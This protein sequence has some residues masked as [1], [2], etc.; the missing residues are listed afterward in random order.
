M[1]T[2]DFID[3]GLFC[4]SRG[5]ENRHQTVNTTDGEYLLDCHVVFLRINEW[6]QY[7]VNSSH[8]AYF[9]T[10]AFV[11][12]FYDTRQLAVFPPFVFCG[13]CSTA[14]LMMIAAMILFL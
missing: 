9:S 11:R 12:L 3:G 14:P 6:K 5:V 4:S 10:N 1:A 2:C 8:P 7:S 13:I